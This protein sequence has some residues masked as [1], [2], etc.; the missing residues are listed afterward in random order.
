MTLTAI[1]SDGSVTDIGTVTTNGYYGTFGNAWTPPKE[2]VYTI[3][4]SFGGDDS[5]GSSS[6]ATSVSVGPAPSVAPTTTAQTK[7]AVR[8]RNCHI[9]CNLN[10]RSSTVQEKIKRNETFL[11]SPFLV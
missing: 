8:R 9:S 10:S 2:G 7:I 4:A 1:G 11:F 6:A 5:Y 3:M